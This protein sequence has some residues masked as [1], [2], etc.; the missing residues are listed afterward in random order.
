ML[1]GTDIEY[2]IIHGDLVIKDIKKIMLIS[3]TLEINCEQ[4]YSYSECEFLVTS[5]KTT[6][7]YSLFTLCII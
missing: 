4:I 7:M 1:F 2:L 6:N 5:I 3:C